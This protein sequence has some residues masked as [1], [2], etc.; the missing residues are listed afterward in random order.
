[1]NSGQQ[2]T[3]SPADTSTDQQISST[4][5]NKPVLPRLVTSTSSDIQKTMNLE[6]DLSQRIVRDGKQSEQQLP[7]DY[8]IPM[9][10]P[11]SMSS[12]QQFAQ[13]SAMQSHPVMTQGRRQ[14]KG[15]QLL[16]KKMQGMKSN[17]GNHVS[18][19]IANMN[20]EDMALTTNIPQWLIYSWCSKARDKTLTDRRTQAAIA[21]LL[22]VKQYVFPCALAL[23]MPSGQ[24]DSLSRNLLIIFR[25]INSVLT[26]SQGGTMSAVSSAANSNNSL[27][28]PSSGSPAQ[29]QV[30]KPMPSSSSA[31]KVPQQHQADGTS[32]STVSVAKLSIGRRQRDHTVAFLEAMIAEEVEEAKSESTL[33]RSN[34]AIAKLLSLYANQTGREYLFLM[35][36][37]VI[38]KV[39]AMGNMEVDPAKFNASQSAGTLPQSDN[40]TVAANMK[41]LL[42]ATKMVLYS[43]TASA[44]RC[45]PGLKKLCYIILRQVEQKFSNNPAL[46]MQRRSVQTNATGGSAA[47]T[48]T[49][50]THLSAPADNEMEVVKSSAVK[51]RQVAVSGFIFL[52][53]IC[54]AIVSPENY[55]LIPH[56]LNPQQRR[57]LILISKVLQNLANG[58]RFGN[59]EAFMTPANSFL[60][61]NET[62]MISY[63]E[64]LQAIDPDM[65]YWNTEIEG[66]EDEQQKRSGEFEGALASALS[67]ANTHL[68]RV[69]D[70]INHVGVHE[71]MSYTVFGALKSVL[72]RFEAVEKA[73][74]LTGRDRSMWQL[75]LRDQPMLNNFVLLGG[76]EEVLLMNQYVLI[77]ALISP[78][79]FANNRNLLSPT[80]SSGP[81]TNTA[82][83]RDMDSLARSVV[84][85][86]GPHGGNKLADVIEWLIEQELTL[87]QTTSPQLPVSE[88]LKRC[89]EGPIVPRA[90]E[91]SAVVM[92]H[93]A[94]FGTSM[95]FKMLISFF[96]AHTKDYLRPLLSDIILEIWKSDLNYEIDPSKL[97][98]EDNLKVNLDN[99]VSATLRVFY[100]ITSNGSQAPDSLKRIV[101]VLYFR[102]T[103]RL[104]ISH[105]MMINSQPLEFDQTAMKIITTLLFVRYCCLVIGSPVFYGLV[106]EPE[107]TPET[108]HYKEKSR[109]TFTL[110]SYIIRFFVT[111]I[112]SDRSSVSPTD[113]QSDESLPYE[114][115][116]LGPILDQFNEGIAELFQAIFGLQN[117]NLIVPEVNESTPSLT[118]SHRSTAK[119]FDAPIQISNTSRAKGIYLLRKI[120]APY[121]VNR[122]KA[123]VDVREFRESLRRM[124]RQA[125]SLRQSDNTLN[126]E[127]SKE[128]LNGLRIETVNYK[129][130][131]RIRIVMASVYRDQTN[132]SNNKDSQTPKT[133][134]D[135]L[136]ESP[137][138][139]TGAKVATSS[140]KQLANLSVSTSQQKNTSNS[141]LSS[142]VS[143]ANSDIPTSASIPSTGANQSSTQPP[144]SSKASSPSQVA[145][146]NANISSTGKWG[147]SMVAQATRNIV[148][149]IFAGIKPHGAGHTSEDAHPDIDDAVTSG[150]SKSRKALPSS[151]GVSAKQSKNSN[152]VASTSTKSLSPKNNNGVPAQGQLPSGPVVVANQADRGLISIMRANILESSGITGTVSTSASGQTGSYDASVAIAIGVEAMGVDEDEDENMMNIE[153]DEDGQAITNESDS[154]LNIPVRAKKL[155]RKSH[156]L[157]STPPVVPNTLGG[158][159]QQGQSSK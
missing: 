119:A 69:N 134:S 92:E 11:A 34:N 158:Q 116:I 89:V 50:A 21:E 48:P 150:S 18:T 40:A 101:R 74:D 148:R 77:K 103:G 41:K 95:S 124:P 30:F 106:Q 58:V 24:H 57:S 29:S 55:G 36:R 129:L 137:K 96:F 133:G 19:L 6:Q 12:Q 111:R 51:G 84:Q 67:Q 135:A 132:K 127:S 9:P 144:G 16:H 56:Q 46:T 83:N 35:L 1:M 38:G 68:E 117:P 64:S 105:D 8:S 7:A 62:L 28:R 107:A 139:L 97:G 49:T 151:F 14:S 63:L 25:G 87:R 120:L 78:I 157:S 59:K 125:S 80:L 33:F 142:P 146:S 17:N 15:P 73:L 118:E 10:S 121:A 143:V 91:D 70:K 126:S 154:G 54:P 90:D 130:M 53:F 23:S 37:D 81:A 145:A 153:V 122:L 47:G 147:N 131:D 98:P 140:A 39:M 71:V 65:V 20:L 86:L 85:L 113:T 114:K 102:L 42:T 43:V 108:A 22:V 93:N 82:I 31:T 149:S 141:N 100:A 61:E 94:S 138:N 104:Q 4:Q 159:I 3:Q 13:Q 112:V 72:R 66:T 2:H 152:G 45:P 88:I 128:E 136:N 26:K 44:P 5:Q 156:R 60:E 32:M 109:R 99:L 123:L 76:L 110:I 79:N 52:R 75:T 155:K 115:E 27:D